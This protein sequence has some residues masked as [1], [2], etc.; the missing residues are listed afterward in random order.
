MHPLQF[1]KFAGKVFSKKFGI[2]LYN[3]K[4]VKKVDKKFDMV[5]SN[6][7]FVG[8]AKY[9]SMVEGNKLPPAKFSGIAEF[10]RL[11]EKSDAS[12]KFLV[13]GN[14]IE[15]PQEWLKKWGKLV[16]KVEF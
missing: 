4:L 10:V 6:G 1:E 8:D 11:L 14:Q 3:N 9:L 13:F 7:K 5:S 12:R 2:K 15:V 16:K